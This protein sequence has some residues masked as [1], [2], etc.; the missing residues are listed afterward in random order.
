M[1][2]GALAKTV[3]ILQVGKYEITLFMA[4]GSPLGIGLKE[5]Q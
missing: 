5:L 2:V 1:A 3:K 4:A